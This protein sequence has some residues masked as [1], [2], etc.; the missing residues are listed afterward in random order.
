MFWECT[1]WLGHDVVDGNVCSNVGF[2]QG[3]L[4]NIYNKC[5][6][7]WIKLVLHSTSFVVPHVQTLCRS[8]GVG[9]EVLLLQGEVDISVG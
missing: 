1:R 7:G 8:R 2:I 4:S 5:T 3:K 9:K 6:D